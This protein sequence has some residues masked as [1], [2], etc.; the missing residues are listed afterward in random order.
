MMGISGRPKKITYVCR[1]CGQVVEVTKDP[2]D[3]RAVR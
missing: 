2:A 1:R 3:L